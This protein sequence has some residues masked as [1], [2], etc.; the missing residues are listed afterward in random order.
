MRKKL[1]GL[2]ILGIVLI[3]GLSGCFSHRFEVIH[4]PDGSGKLT[5]ETIFTEEY[6][7]IFDEGVTME[8]AQED[9]LAESMFT[10]ENLPDDTNIRSVEEKDFI[11][12]TTGALH[13]SL[14]IEIIDI[15]TPVFFEEGDDLSNIF[16]VQDNGDGTFLFTANLE[17][18]SEFADEDEDEDFM[19]DPEMFRFMLQGSTITW[20]LHVEEFIEG[21]TQAVYDVANNTVN[22]EL[23]M[24][25]VLF[26]EEPLEIFAIYRVD[27]A[28]AVE[29]EPQEVLM[30]TPDPD[31]P[32]PEIPDPDTP[33]LVIPDPAET[34][35]RPP[36]DFEVDQPSDGFFGLPNWVPIVLVAVLCLGGIFVVIAAV[37]II[38]VVRKG[39][40]KPPSNQLE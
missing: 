34:D 4:N 15:L 24:Y 37:I 14:E 10:R 40:Q 32:D 12:P 7:D 29:P 11:D 38:L 5:I 36:V 27:S 28:E 18:M 22:W 8:E 1:F 19:M 6:L 21:D 35:I 30:P 16:M 31:T 39:K 3:L 25:D 23:P 2:T 9:I 33:E 20:Q 17:S 26:A 13:H